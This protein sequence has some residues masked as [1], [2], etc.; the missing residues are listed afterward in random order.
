MAV[1]SLVLGISSFV[2]WILAGIPAIITGLLAMGRIRRSDGRLEGKGLAVA[3]VTTGAVTSLL[4]LP[5][6]VGLLLPAVQAARAAAQRNASMNNMKMIALA[7]LNHAD[8]RR[9]FPAAGGGSSSPLS[10][11]VHLLPFLGEVSLYRQFH[12]DEPWDSP[13]N[14]SLIARMP[15]VYKSPDVDLPEGHT[16]YLGVAGDG[17]AF[18]NRD[19]G[20]T[21]RDLLG[22]GRRKVLFVEADP[23]Q[24]VPWTK[25]QDW[26]YTSDGPLDGVGGIRPN[27][28]LAVFADGSVEMVWSDTDRK[29]LDAALSGD[30]PQQVN[31][32]LFGAVDFNVM[33]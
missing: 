11:R 3:G 29:T 20:A 31:L 12:L 22:G 19:I 10:W 15:D 32:N 8:S 33:D 28:F 18:G 4:L 17:A 16:N 6:V 14:R 30:A 26:Q 7:M 1:T 9:A 24:A 27:G 13:H 21:N 25:P 2:F 5:I 23:D